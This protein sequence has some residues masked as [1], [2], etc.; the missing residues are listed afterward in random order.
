ML[1]RTNVNPSF[2]ITLGLIALAL[3]NVSHYLLHR[4]GRPGTSVTDGVEGFMFGIA[5][6]ALLLGV[7]LRRRRVSKR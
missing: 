7:Y 5:I 6:G 1:L 4:N 3:A 2:I